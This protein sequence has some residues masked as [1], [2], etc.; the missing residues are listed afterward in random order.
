MGVLYLLFLQ[1]CKGITF[2]EKFDLT[3][4]VYLM[5][6]KDILCESLSTLLQYTQYFNSMRSNS[7]SKN[8]IR[9]F[10]NFPT[11][12]N[13][14]VFII[15]AKIALLVMALLTSTITALTSS[16]DFAN[17]LRIFF[18]LCM[19]DVFK[20]LCKLEEYLSASTPSY[21]FIN[22]ITMVL[23]FSSELLFC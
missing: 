12:V 13:F 6:D 2:I 1:T 16:A 23:V 19:I 14:A 22:S 4:N 21:G 17:F 7:P 20:L 15:F 18:L 5:S 9:F 11:F 10:A 8:Q 3:N